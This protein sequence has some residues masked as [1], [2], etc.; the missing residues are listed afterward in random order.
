[1]FI[2]NL[3]HFLDKKV[4]IPADMLKEGREIAGFIALIVDTVIKDCPSAEK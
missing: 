2:S 4:N 1:M 3:I